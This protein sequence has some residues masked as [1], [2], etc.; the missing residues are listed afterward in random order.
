MR[1][2]GPHI[3]PGIDAVG[4]GTLDITSR[5]IE[6][7]FVVADVNADGRQ[8]GKTSLER[9]REWIVGVGAPEIG[10]HQS[11]YLLLRKVRIGVRTGLVR[12]AR[13]RQISDRATRQPLQQEWPWR[14]TALAATHEASTS[15]RFPPA[16][17]PVM[18]IRRIPLSPSRGK[19]P[20]H[21]QRLQEKG[22]R[23]QGDSPAQTPSRPPSRRCARPGGDRPWRFPRRT[24]R[25]ANAEWLRRQID[26][27]QDEPR[28]PG[29]R[30][31]WPIRMSR[32][33]AAGTPSI[34]AS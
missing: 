26:S 18:A 27:T 3:K 20:A 23:E 24:T 15:A 9:R 33:H 13:E 10:I 31:P 28:G 1:H 29:H 14:T 25:R 30:R 16:E 34:S 12:S 32:R 21:H 6:Q 19:P 17:S 2:A 8:P 4:D 7:H 22:V 5:V 11:A